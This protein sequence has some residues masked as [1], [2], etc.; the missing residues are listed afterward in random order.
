MGMQST[1]MSYG[2]CLSLSETSV[3]SMD[4]RTPDINPVADTSNGLVV[5]NIANYPFYKNFPPPPNMNQ[6]VSRQQ[7]VMM[8]PDVT[9][10]Y[11]VSAM[12]SLSHMVY[13]MSSLIQ[14]TLY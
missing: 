12:Y 9:S 10:T 6:K 7:T 11:P 13:T 2:D 8:W 4:M 3:S 1:P 14:F 5:Q